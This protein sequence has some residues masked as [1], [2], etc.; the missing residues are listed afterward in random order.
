MSQKP[1]PL[2]LPPKPLASIALALSGGGFRSAA[3][4]LG[5]LSYLKR[6]RVESVSQGQHS[7]LQHVT[8][9]STVSGGSLTGALYALY[10]SRGMWDSP[11]DLANP[12]AFG[13]FYKKLW[14]FLQ[15]DTLIEQVFTRLRPPINQYQKTDKSWN[16]INAFARTYNATL[17]NNATF[18]DTLPNGSS[19]L[20]EVCFNATEFVTG[21][22][23]RFQHSAIASILVGNGNLSLTDSQVNGKIKLADIVASSSC[24]P[25]GFE[26]MLFPHDFSHEQLNIDQLKASVRFKA[27]QPN[28]EMLFPFGLM[29][30]GTSENQGISSLLMADNR[31]DEHDTPFVDLL[32]IAD[33]GSYFMDPYQAQL[34]EKRGIWQYL[35]PILLLIVLGTL[36]GGSVALWLVAR[37]PLWQTIGLLG[38]GISTGILGMS[39]LL[40]KLLFYF[41]TGENSADKQPGSWASMLSK[42]GRQ[43]SRIRISTL[44]QMIRARLS[45]VFLLNDTVFLKNI[46]RLVYQSA[47]QDRRWQFRLITTLVYELGKRNRLHQKPIKHLPTSPDNVSLDS[48]WALANNSPMEKTAESAASMATTLWFDEQEM[49]AGKLT[50]LIAC[51]QFTACYN[52]YEYIIKLENVRSQAVD[53]EEKAYVEQVDWTSLADLKRQLTADWIRFKENPV[54]LHQQLLTDYKTPINHV[55]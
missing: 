20:K 51:G 1:S 33:V 53:D 36:I 11:D 2:S 15:G 32:L 18:G 54:W 10:S 14:E 9:L 6:L 39:Y 40:Y 47:Y 17:F 22:S 21:V 23:F 16:L 30:G 8:H 55:S 13:N 31:N 28:Q 5:T 34:E 49:Q 29:D 46:R 25:S 27:Q 52:L 7:L 42:Y 19:P 43:F 50:D 37:Q 35:S 38:V 26:P 12:W 44:Q 24:F 48:I 41:F 3:F 45:S 4:A